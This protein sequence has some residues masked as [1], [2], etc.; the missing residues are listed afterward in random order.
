MW[1]FSGSESALLGV[2]G[3]VQLS[4][5]KLDT[6]TVTSLF[7]TRQFVFFHLCDMCVFSLDVYCDS[8]SC[9]YFEF[10]HSSVIVCIIWNSDLPLNIIM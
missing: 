10:L 9:I 2:L 5:L 6:W 3:E 1:V 8:Y 4:H 7:L